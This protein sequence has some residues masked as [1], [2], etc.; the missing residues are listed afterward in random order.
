M[1]VAELGG[2]AAVRNSKHI[3]RGPLLFSEAAMR[4]LIRG[5]ASGTIGGHRS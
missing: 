4:A 1:E 5:I 2:H 3:S